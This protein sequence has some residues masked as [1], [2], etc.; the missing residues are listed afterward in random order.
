MSSSD[1]TVTY[2]SV[3][4][5]DVPFW[6]DGPVDYPI[7]EGYNG[8]DDDSDSSGDDTDDKDEDEEDKEEEHL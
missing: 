7:D 1:S 3:S 8:D 5:E 4:S 6:E 2:T